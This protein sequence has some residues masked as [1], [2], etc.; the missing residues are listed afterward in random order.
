MDYILGCSESSIE[1]SRVPHFYVI[2]ESEGAPILC[3]STNFP[4]SMNQR[5]FSV[6]SKCHHFIKNQFK[7]E[8]QKIHFRH[9][10]LYCF[11]RGF[12]VLQTL[13]PM[14]PESDLFSVYGDASVTHQTIRKWYRRFETGNF[15][16]EDQAHSGLKKLMKRFLRISCIKVLE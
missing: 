11:K 2:N 1:I 7:M 16:V 8:N 4:G 13:N 9:V 6:F 10:M 14:N 5:N 3:F 12:I 15:N